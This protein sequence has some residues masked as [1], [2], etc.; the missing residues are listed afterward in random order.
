MKE[1]ICVICGKNLETQDYNHYELPID[2]LSAPEPEP[3]I[4]CT[5]PDCNQ[6]VI[7]GPAE[8]WC[9]LTYY[10]RRKAEGA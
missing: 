7:E 2:D 4:C 3:I 6:K 5:D 1:K 8:R 10:T 9:V